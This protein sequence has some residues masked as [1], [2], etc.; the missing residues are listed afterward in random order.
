[1]TGI[2]DQLDNITMTS[3]KAGFAVALA[4]V[5]EFCT[6]QAKKNHTALIDSRDLIAH[7]R[8]L[9]DECDQHLSI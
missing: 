5:A 8:V 7:I 2:K 1:M 3:R 9:Q 6:E 4:K